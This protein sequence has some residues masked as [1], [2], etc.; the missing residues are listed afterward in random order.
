MISTPF[1]AVI[2]ASLVSNASIFLA[3]TQA[4]RHT[5]RAKQVH[6]DRNCGLRG[7]LKSLSL[8]AV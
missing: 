8:V 2:Y 6:S 5:W 3:S 7:F 1:R 4:S